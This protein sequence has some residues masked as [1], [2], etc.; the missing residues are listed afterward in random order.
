[1][2]A[3]NITG[4]VIVTGQGPDHVLFATDLPQSMW[5]YNG[6]AT[7]KMDVAAGAGAQYVRDNFKLPFDA[8][9][10]VNGGGAVKPSKGG[11]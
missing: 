4:A 8:I 1:M 7:L 5:P 2:V 11:S 3:I 6:T 9:K 10:V